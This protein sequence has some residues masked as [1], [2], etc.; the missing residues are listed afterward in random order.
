[1]MATVRYVTPGAGHTKSQA[2]WFL[3]HRVY[4]G[5]K[6]VKSAVPGLSSG[7]CKVSCTIHHLCTVN[8]ISKNSYFYIICTQGTLPGREV[9]H[10]RLVPPRRISGGIPLRPHVFM[11]RT[12]R[13]LRRYFCNTDHSDS[14]SQ[15][16]VNA[17]FNV[18]K[19]S[20]NFRYHQ[21]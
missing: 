7:S 19:P 3:F 2:A 8:V 11:P 20:G 14:W 18:F 15:C 9:N 12:E 13:T 17:R 10:T 1:M 4:R 16:A 6:E 21:E 5:N